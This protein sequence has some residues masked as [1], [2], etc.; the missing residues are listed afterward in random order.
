MD[1][2]EHF[3]ITTSSCSVQKG[4]IQHP[5]CSVSSLLIKQCKS[6]GVGNGEQRGSL[7]SAVASPSMNETFYERAANKSTSVQACRA[8]SY[9]QQSKAPLNLFQRSL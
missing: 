8:R 6:A 5:A 4:Q 9:L 1:E 7:L 3:R 2:Y